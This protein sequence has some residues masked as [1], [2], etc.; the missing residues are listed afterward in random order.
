MNARIGAWSPWLLAGGVIVSGL[1]GLIPAAASHAILLGGLG[2]AAWQRWRRTRGRGGE[3]EWIE[4]AISE[5]A[6]GNL[7]I[8]ATSAD[9]RLPAG[10]IE[11]IN[12]ALDVVE[13]FMHEV[14]EC[15]EAAARQDF[16]RL[17]LARDFPGAFGETLER[18]N[19]AMR[20]LAE[21]ETLKGRVELLGELMGRVAVQY[22]HNLGQYRSD[23]KE[24]EQ[25]LSLLA[26]EIERTRVLSAERAAEAD[27]LTSQIAALGRRVE[28]QAQQAEQLQEVSRSIQ[29]TVAL[30]TEITDQTNL[31]AL[32]A[33]IEAARAGSFG[34]GFGVVADEVRKLA[35]R[36]RLAA[37]EIHRFVTLFD[38]TVAPIGAEMRA[39]HAA[40]SE[41][42]KE[43]ESFAFEFSQ[44]ADSATQ[45]KFTLNKMIDLSRVASVAIDHLLVVNQLY[46]TMS[47]TTTVRREELEQA[48]RS[49]LC[50]LGQW[51]GSAEAQSTFGDTAAFRDLG[52]HHRAFHE[53]MHAVLAIV[54]DQPE[55][56]GMAPAVREEFF[57][58]VDRCRRASELL[59]RDL[60]AM[61][62]QKYEVQ[63]F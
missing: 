50:A 5:A 18:I 40:F 13:L 63:L 59:L 23:L 14:R 46:V 9:R 62:E 48:K 35:D 58:A 20:A 39:L 16:Q 44:V 3:F 29:R 38:Q 55:G 26:E 37:E 11:K 45:N 47:T 36:T 25:T 54:A 1:A 57:A 31:L 17:A 60:H 42:G 27:K 32:N 28:V 19:V 15:F 56:R 4:T 51:Y 61:V 43:T 52:E 30:I 41:A 6:A 53:A 10:L 8:R 22:E 33:A 21:H 49:D 12:R 2:V 24:I 34:R 7:Q